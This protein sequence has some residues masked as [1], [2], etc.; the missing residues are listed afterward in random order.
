MP[1]PTD[2]K[3]DNRNDFSFRRILLQCLPFIP[4]GFSEQILEIAI[5]WKETRGTRILTKTVESDFLPFY[6]TKI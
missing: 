1:K 2:E 5:D 6:E 4:K 3:D